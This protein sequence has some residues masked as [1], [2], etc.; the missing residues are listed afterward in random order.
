VWP[1]WSLRARRTSP[2]SPCLITMHVSI[3][4]AAM[5]GQQCPGT[6]ALSGADMMTPHSD[7]ECG[8]TP[9]RPRPVRMLALATTR[10]RNRRP[11]RRHERS[12]GRRGSPGP[13]C[14]CRASASICEPRA[15]ARLIAMATPPY[16]GS[17]LR[18]RCP[19]V[20]AAPAGGRHR[21][22]RW[23]ASRHGSG[24]SPTWRG[25]SARSTLHGEEPAN[26][27]GFRLPPLSA[28]SRKAQS[29]RM[30]GLLA[31]VL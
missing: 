2:P 8:S 17:P 12:P 28:K 14:R 22:P 11:R 31:H 5:S 26:H 6:R 27:G 29:L 7:R 1:R 3:V 23:P 21:W 30:W 16:S 15:P 20:P 24:R 9:Y 10:S 25:I 13:G 19:V 4:G 18:P